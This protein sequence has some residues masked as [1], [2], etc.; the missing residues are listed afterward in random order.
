[1]SSKKPDIVMFVD[2]V[3]ICKE[4]PLKIAI[5]DVGVDYEATPNVPVGEERVSITGIYLEVIRHEQW[6]NLA[7]THD[8][9]ALLLYTRI[10]DQLIDSNRDYIDHMYTSA[11]L[12]AEYNA[13]PQVCSYW[14]YP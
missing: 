13:D 3:V 4:P 10:H 7:S 2:E 14:R 1:M 12:V 5:G 11:G 8:P 9:L 6:I